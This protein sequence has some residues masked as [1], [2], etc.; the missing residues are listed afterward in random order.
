M[1]ANKQIR[2]T[3]QKMAIWEYL[4]S[5]KTHPPAEEI[6]N[7]VRK[8]LPRITLATVY[9]NLKE[10]SQ[11]GIIQEIPD[12]VLR[13]DG[14]ISLH[15]HFICEECGK[16]YDVFGK[17]GL[18]KPASSKV[19]KIKKHQIYFYGICKKCG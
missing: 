17:C 11:Q 7:Q 4:K 12:K 2:F 19:G 10:M 16:I 6:Y 8:A 1:D 14:D 13:Y 3:N 9:R 5:V 18:I 15:A